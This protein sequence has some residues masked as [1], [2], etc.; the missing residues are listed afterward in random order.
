MVEEGEPAVRC[1][2]LARRRHYEE[3]PLD[4]QRLPPGPVRLRL[5]ALE[6]R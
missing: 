1:F 5:E 2:A 3:E 4:L 6:E